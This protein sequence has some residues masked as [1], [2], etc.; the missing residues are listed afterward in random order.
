VRAKS[1]ATD[2][3]TKRCA[4]YTR[5][6]HEKGLDQDFN[7]LDAQRETCVRYIQTQPGWTVLDET[8]EDGG[9]TG[10]NT[11]RPAFQRLLA[12]VDAGKID[13]IVVYKLDR[14][15][16]SLLDFLKLQEEL[17][18]RGCGVVSVTQNFN[19]ADAMGRLILN[20]LMSFAQFEREMTAERIRDKVAAAR[21]KGKW[22]GGVVPFGFEVRDK[23]LVMNELEAA[24]VRAAFELFVEHEQLSVAARLLTERALP[25]RRQIK[26]T[27]VAVRR[28]VRNPLYAGLCRAGDDLTRG[29][30][31]AIVD[32][33]LFRAA[34]DIL[35]GRARDRVDH[36]RN[37][38]YLLQ[39]LLRC[40]LCGRS[41]T[42][43]STRKGAREYRYYR[44][45]G[46]NNN[47][48]DACGATNAAA[49]S[50]E[51]YVATKIVSRAAGV[52]SVQQTKAAL[53]AHLERRRKELDLERAALPPQIAATSAKAAQYLHGMLTSRGREGRPAT[54]GRAGR[55]R[56]LRC[57]RRGRRV[58]AT[59]TLALHRIEAGRFSSATFL[60]GNERPPA[61]RHASPS[62]S[63]WLT[64]SSARSTAA[65]SR[66]S[67]T[68]RAG[69][70]SRR[71]ASH[72]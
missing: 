39:G 71:P 17:D 26:W 33:E 67:R 2:S 10:K 20:V 13:V 46:R 58:K 72:R 59:V 68:S 11:D 55:A 50:I 42:P 19:T 66:V 15:S 27:K 18:K 44:C 5:K 69:S 57:Q 4:I 30:H 52:L 45:S 3:K 36:G 7:S 9:F 32:D 14:F 29:E 25:G 34:Q 40:G 53:D 22:T 16:R 63:R 56:A 28:L 61:V 24:T 6:S 47:G 38:D 37:D 12:D 21:R 1:Q 8:Y 43:A 54:G 48:S 65:R 70:G 41:M 31:K 51:E 23:R 60:H 35:D 62:S 64:T 49:A